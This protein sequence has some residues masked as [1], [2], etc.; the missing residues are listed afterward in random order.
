[1]STELSNS[2]SL[3][4]ISIVIMVIAIKIS[5]TRVIVLMKNIDAKIFFS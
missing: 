3:A 2:E 4:T 5:K 1:M